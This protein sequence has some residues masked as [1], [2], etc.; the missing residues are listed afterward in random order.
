MNAQ[1]LRRAV[2][3]LRNVI[4]VVALTTGAV[5]ILSATGSAAFAQVPYTDPDAKGDLTLCDATYKLLQEGRTVDRPFVWRA[6]GSQRAAPPNDG[7]GRLGTLFAFQPV[8]GVSPGEWVGE[9]ISGATRYM[10]PDRPMSQFTE[11]DYAI[12]IFIDRFP[13]RWDGYLQLRLLFSSP[14]QSAAADYAAMDLQVKDGRWRVLRGGS[15][16]CGAPDD[17]VSFERALP[18]FAERVAAAR[19]EEASKAAT[20]PPAPVQSGPPAETGAPSDSP[21]S[22]EPSTAADTQGGD[23]RSADSNGS[24]GDGVGGSDSSAVAPGLVVLVVVVAAVGSAFV[25]SRRLR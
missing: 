21:S 10:N 18:D 12:E 8:E 24:P 15:T 14:G 16:S 22:S 7:E 9:Q 25:V 23:D 2:L 5:G 17:A 20:R 19:V 1:I 11:I 13:L 4:V 6:V 3:G